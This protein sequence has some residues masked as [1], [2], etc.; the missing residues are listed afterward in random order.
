MRRVISIATALCLAST[1]A[2][3]GAKDKSQNTL[4]DIDAAGVISNTL[5]KTKIK[6]KGCKNQIQAQTVSMADGDIAICI[7]EADVLGIGGNSLIITGEAKKGK[8][9]IKADLGEGTI[10]SQGCGDVEAVS[11]NG[12]VKCYLDDPLYRSN[13]TGAGTWRDACTNAGMLPGDSPGPEATYLKVNDTVPVVVGLCQGFSEGD[14]IDPPSST[15][16][17]VTGQRTAIE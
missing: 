16:W 17:A 12:L 4:A 3:A 7:L 8:L 2:W 5:A 11:Y 15:R 10:A 14:R 13:G 1:V 6:A 9:K